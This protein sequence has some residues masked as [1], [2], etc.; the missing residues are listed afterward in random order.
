MKKDLIF[1]AFE[2]ETMPIQKELARLKEINQ[3]LI[4]ITETYERNVLDRFDEIEQYGYICGTNAKKYNLQIIVD[5][6]RLIYEW[7]NSN[8]DKSRFK[9]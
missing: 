1:R 6:G 8:C 3:E 2:D 9:D 4:D 7:Q 5:I